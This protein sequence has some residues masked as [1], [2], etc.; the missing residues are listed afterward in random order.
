M[1]EHDQRNYDWD[2]AIAESLQIQNVPVDITRVQQDFQNSSDER[3]VYTVNQNDDV[4]QSSPVTYLSIAGTDIVGGSCPEFES[5][6]FHARISLVAGSASI[7][8]YDEQTRKYLADGFIAVKELTNTKIKELIERAKI[9]KERRG[10]HRYRDLV[11]AMKL[12][13]LVQ[14]AHLNFLVNHHIKKNINRSQVLSTDCA[15]VLGKSQIKRK[16]FNRIY[17][18]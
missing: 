2:A 1:N 13:S 12:P 15:V 3:V 4:N 6:G 14:N 10:S 9:E 5:A 16:A 11:M 17:T 8:V 7:G 18:T